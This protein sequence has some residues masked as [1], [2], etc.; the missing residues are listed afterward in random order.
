MVRGQFLTDCVDIIG[1]ELV[2]EAWESKL[3]KDA[4]D[5][6]NRLMIAAD[7][8]AVAN[9]LTSLKEQRLPPDASED[10]LDYR[11]NAGIDVPDL[12]FSRLLF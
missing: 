8:I 12:Y 11:E 10:S 4:L 7:K 5:Y 6:G 3:A 1:E 9:N 2:N